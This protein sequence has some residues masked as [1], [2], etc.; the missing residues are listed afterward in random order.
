VS[1]RGASPA[2]RFFAWLPSLAYMGL[3]WA[4]SSQTRQIELPDLPFRDKLAHA[5]EYGILSVLNLWALRRSS[6]HGALRSL[7]TAVLLTSAW[8]YLDEVHQAYVPGRFSD[9]YDWIADTCGA[10]VFASLATIA[11]RMREAALARRARA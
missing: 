4:L 7:F 2:R 11:W 3:I 1:D 5:V 9:V 6:S 10:I 8:G